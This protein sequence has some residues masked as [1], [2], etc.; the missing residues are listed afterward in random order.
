[1]K[2]YCDLDGVVFNTIE[3]ICKMYNNEFKNHPAFK[4]VQWW[5][6][7]T[8]EFKECKL[9]T[10][11]HIDSYFSKKKFFENVKMMNN[12]KIVI[13]NL[14]KQGFKIIFVS[15]GD[16]QNLTLKKKWVKKHFPYAK[17]IGCDF[18][19]YSNK[20]HINMK[21][22]IFIEDSSSNLFSSNAE[23]KI[24]FGEI[25]KWNID[26][27]G[28]RCRFWEDVWEEIMYKIRKEIKLGKN[29]REGEVYWKDKKEKYVW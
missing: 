18:K 13:D 29:L 14:Y 1:M 9:A 22:S 28:R 27:E 16:K 5:E 17:F 4:K 15:M 8:W 10:K 21:G 25:Y 23:Y 6:V 19:E 26:W 24:L 12:S 11:K 2:I 3:C 20:S 7:N